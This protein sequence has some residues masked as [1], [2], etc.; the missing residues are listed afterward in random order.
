MVYI[1]ISGLSTRMAAAWLIVVRSTVCNIGLWRLH[2]RTCIAYSATQP[3]RRK[4]KRQ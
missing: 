1:T 2:V 3:Q 4:L